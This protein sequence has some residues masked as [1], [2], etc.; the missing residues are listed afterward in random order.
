[1]PPAYRCPSAPANSSFTSFAVITGSGTL[2]EGDHPTPM[3]DIPDG[4]SNTLLVVEAAGSNI[5]W[6]EPRDLAFDRMTLV[7]NAPGGHDI[8]SLHGGAIV[9]YADGSARPVS[10]A[11]AP[12]FLRSLITRNGGDGITVEY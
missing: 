9:A 3:D 11:T 10:D 7:I 8:S 2:F 1:M 12:K 4:L 6:M 5:L